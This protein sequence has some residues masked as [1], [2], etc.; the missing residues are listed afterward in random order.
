MIAAMIDGVWLRAA[1]SNWTEADSES[2][3]ALLAT[4]VDFQLKPQN[5][6]VLAPP[7]S[8]AQQRARDGGVVVSINPATGHELARLPVAGAA[9]VDA[10]VARAQEAQRTWAQRTGA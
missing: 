8:F 7:A 6:P 9:E 10:A 3:R 1:L 5:A 2:A 4:F